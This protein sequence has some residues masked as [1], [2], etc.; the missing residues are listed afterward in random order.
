[1]LAPVDNA[2]IEV[3]RRLA[4]DEEIKVWDVASGFWDDTATDVREERDRHG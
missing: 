1:M 3:I 2:P 4:D